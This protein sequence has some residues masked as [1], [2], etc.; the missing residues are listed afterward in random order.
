MIEA[1]HRRGALIAVT[2]E[3]MDEARRGGAAR[4]AFRWPKNLAELQRCIRSGVHL[5]ELC[6]AYER[7]ARRSEYWL[8]SREATVAARAEEYRALASRQSESF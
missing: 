3:K 7:R 5:A 4:F 2:E 6:E 8:R 1:R